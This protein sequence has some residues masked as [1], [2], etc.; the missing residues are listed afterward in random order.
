MK[1]GQA[2]S[3]VVQSHCN[4][5]ILEFLSE[6]ITYGSEMGLKQGGWEGEDK[7]G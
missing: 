6:L 2:G 7:E 3:G 4:Y 5:F 1:I